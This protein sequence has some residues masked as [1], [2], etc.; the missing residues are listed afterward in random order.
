ME[1]VFTTPPNEILKRGDKS[2]FTFPIQAEGNIDLT[3]VDS[4]GEEWQK[5]DSFS[6]QEINQIG[7]NYFDVVKEE[8]YAGKRVLDVGCGTGRWTKYVAQKAAF[9][10]AVDPSDA[11]FSAAVL[12]ANVPNTRISRASVDN[13]PFQH[14][15]FD[16]VFSL[17]VL[18]HI[19]DTESAMLRCVE[20]LKKG[21]YF[22]VYLY[23][24]LDNRG[25]AFKAIFHVSNLLRK[26]VSKLPTGFKKVVCEVLAVLIYLPFIAITHILKALGLRKIAS[27]IPLSWYADKSWKVI[28]ND[29]LDRFGT[30][31]EKRF[32]RLEIEQMMKRCGL[33][34]IIFSEKEPYWHAIGKRV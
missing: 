22:L 11:V 20:K 13:L 19:P 9:V 17:G 14:E 30:P 18:H 21:G 28:R 33:D 23:Y 8:Y 6:E 25:A 2:I 27:F 10:D 5:F 15:T 34:E 32:S 26:V 29:S 12:L 24:N 3:T 7:D 16:F 1:T 4:F 31:L